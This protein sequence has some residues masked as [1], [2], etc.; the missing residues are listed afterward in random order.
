[1]SRSSKWLVLVV[2]PMAFLLGGAVMQRRDVDART[3][4]CE[5]LVI[6]DASGKMRATIGLEQ[7]KAVVKLYDPEE[8]QGIVLGVGGDGTSSFHMFYPNQEGKYF[9][10]G[11]IAAKDGVASIAIRDARSGAATMH[12]HG[13]SGGSEIV[14]SD[15]KGHSRTLRPSER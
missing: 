14:V 3:V 2:V 5:K 6:R 8:H 15:S 11:M 10:I 12:L 4:T 9:A 7:T 13:G 1:M